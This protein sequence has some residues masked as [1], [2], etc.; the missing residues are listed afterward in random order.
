MAGGGSQGSLAGVVVAEAVGVA[1]EVEHDGAVQE[2][3]EHRG[4]DGGVAQDLAPGGDPG[5]GGQDDA[6]F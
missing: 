5:V 2:P 6:G 3:V 4:G 1:L